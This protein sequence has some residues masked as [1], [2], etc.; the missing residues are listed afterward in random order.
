MHLASN[1]RP[2]SETRPESWSF[3][4]SWLLGFVLVVYL[5]LGGGGFDLLI[6]GQVGIAIWWIL[7]LGFAVG[8]LPRRRP[9]PA[10]L[11]LFALLAAFVAWTALSLTWS[12]SFEKTAIDL[13]RM[14]T[15]LGVFGMAIA[16]RDRGSSTHMVQAVAAGI[17]VIS[18]VA[19]LS[20]LHPSWFPEAAETGR[21]LETG[22]ER[23]SYPLDYWNGLAALIGIGLPLM[24]VVA[25]RSGSILVRGLAAA[26]MPVM[27]L[28][29][30]FTL[31]RGG[32][33]ASLLGIAILLV[34]TN[35]RLTQ[36]V[37]VIVTGI[38]GGILVVIGLKS[39]DLAHGLN[40]ATAHSQGDRL[41]WITIGVCLL[42]GVVQALIAYAARRR[43][44]PAWSRVSRQQSLY[45]VGIAALVLIVALLA[46]GAPGKL[47]NAWD[48][49]KQ[50]SN[51][52]EQGTGRLTSAGGENRYQFWSSAAREYESK[53]LTGTGSGTFQLWW[54][55]DG[56]FA[57]PVVDTHNL[58]MQTIGELGIIGL[59][60]LVAFIV[61]ALWIGAG[62]VLRAGSS[63]RPYLAAALAGS[64]VLWTTSIF[65]WMW[66]IPIIPIATL[67]LLA[68][69]ITAGDPEPAERPALGVLG[70][71]AV[72]VV[73]AAAIVAIAIPLASESLV[74]ESQSKARAGDTSGALSEARSAANVEPEA[75]APHLQ[76]A[77]LLEAQGDFPAAEAEAKAATERESTNWR[78]WLILSRIEA[79]R[80][81][82]QAALAAYRK[83]RSLNP[84]SSIFAEAERGE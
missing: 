33:A 11:G 29:L 67:L 40:T 14:V 1:D 50:P 38:G 84:D 25:C 42:V 10:A 9:G 71:I 16:S 21:F 77:L 44:R 20:W 58:Y 23:L 45:A 76:Q 31:S 72:V 54:T 41:L 13:A 75:A 82:A 24:L 69:L 39:H 56:D 52:S 68:V 66:K 60:L 55:R 28:A 4:W 27:L 61:A 78:T 46:I 48:N 79:Q 59:A 12:E 35:D 26:A 15:V 49:F 74:R 51:H 73:S 65:D 47:S 8:A 2:N 81:Q 7:L 6:S 32:I 36:L 5:G 43:E 80:G 30:L 17:F 83:A 57:A 18:A 63:K 53:P 70:R 34:A 37:T 62:R 64:T 3:A 19:L 22:K